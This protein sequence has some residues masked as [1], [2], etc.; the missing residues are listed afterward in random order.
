MTEDQIAK[1]IAKYDALLQKAGVS[2]ARYPSE[3]LSPQGSEALSH[4]RWMCQEAVGSLNK[5]EKDKAMRWLCFIQGVLWMT[6]TSNIDG[7]RDDNR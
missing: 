6:G 2:P 4:A 1:A 3:K 5:G 7:L